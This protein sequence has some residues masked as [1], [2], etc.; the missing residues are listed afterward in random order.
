MPAA[1]TRWL[2]VDGGYAGA[3]DRTRARAGWGEPLHRQRVRELPVPGLDDR[4]VRLTVW[5]LLNADRLRRNLTQDQYGEWLGGSGSTLSR[6]R[7]GE[8]KLSKVMYQRLYERFPAWRKRLRALV[9]E[10]ALH[11][12]TLGAATTD[13]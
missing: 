9:L 10:D 5:E 11:D 13:D 4:P 3:D 7:R 6:F 12:G 8:R 2:E 1:A